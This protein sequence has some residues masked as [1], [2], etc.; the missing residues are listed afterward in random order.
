MIGAS[1]AH[2][3]KLFQGDQPLWPLETLTPLRIILGVFK[4]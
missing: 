2:L 3:L 1:I 4:V